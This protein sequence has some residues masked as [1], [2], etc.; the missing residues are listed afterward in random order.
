MGTAAVCERESGLG[1]RSNM[2]A[3]GGK[4]LG[5]CFL[6]SKVEIMVLSTCPPPDAGS[7]E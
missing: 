4:S 1:S 5:G 3:D 2:S 7:N 6:T